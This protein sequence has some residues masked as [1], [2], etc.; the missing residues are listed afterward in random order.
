LF[1]EKWNKYGKDFSLS[2][3][4]F[5]SRT[6]KGKTIKAIKNIGHK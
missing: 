3:K 4:F 2:I 1:H 5:K 6:K